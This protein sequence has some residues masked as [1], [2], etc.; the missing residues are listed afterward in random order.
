[1]YSEEVVRAEVER[2]SDEKGCVAKKWCERR[3]SEAVMRGKV[4]SG[5][6][7]KNYLVAVH[8][9]CVKY[10]YKTCSAQPR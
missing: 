9:L 5:V 6:L 1:M 7:V 8:I 10:T 4:E 2:G 3:S